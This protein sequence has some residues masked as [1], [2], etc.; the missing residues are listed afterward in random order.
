[1][2]PHK[3]AIIGGIGSGK[4]VVSRLFRLMNIPVYDCDSEAKRL[5]N[6]S[7]ALRSELIKAIDERVYK[8]DGVIDRAYL[9]SFMF[10]NAQHVALVNSIVTSTMAAMLV[11]QK[12]LLG[13]AQI[14][15]EMHMPFS[16]MQILVM[17]RNR[18]MSIGDLSR[19]L[20]IAKPNITPLVDEMC[21]SGLVER[22][23]DE[24]DRR[25][26]KVSLLEAGY[27][28]LDAIAACEAER[29]RAWSENI[30]RSE[31]RELNRSLQSLLRILDMLPDEM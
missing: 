6:T 1:M 18:P 12:R 2:R 11:L 10:G 20:A 28:K 3:I 14:V 7:A 24:Q 26:V 19:K 17:L 8:A 5:M 21:E 13:V 25:V 9:A 16:H 15:R 29:I 30:S 22:V 23:R 4:S 31:I 27:Q